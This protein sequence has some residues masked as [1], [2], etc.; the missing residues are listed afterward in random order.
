MPVS[1]LNFSAPS[2]A[3]WL[4]ERS[5]LPPKSKTMAGWK[6]LAARA[7]PPARITADVSAKRRRGNFMGGKAR[8]KRGLAKL[9]KT[10][11]VSNARTRGPGP[12]GV[13]LRWRTKA[14]HP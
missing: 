7:A 1:F 8:P 14:D 4:N 13:R 9:G 10:S 2:L 12:I 5:N 11:V 3:D 6:S